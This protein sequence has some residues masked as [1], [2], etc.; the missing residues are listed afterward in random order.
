MTNY[1]Y[2]KFTRDYTDKLQAELD[3][4]CER[5]KYDVEL[6]PINVDV[7][8]RKKDI[9]AV[10]YSDALSAPLLYLNEKYSMF[11]DA[12]E[13]TNNINH[14]MEIL[15]NHTIRQLAIIKVD[16]PLDEP[17]TMQSVNR[18]VY[19]SAMNFDKNK[20]YLKDMPYEKVGDMALIAVYQI[21]DGN[22]FDIRYDFCQFMRMSPQEIFDIAH[23][24]VDR[25]KYKCEKVVDIVLGELQKGK[26]YKDYIDD[27]FLQNKDIPL[28]RLTNRYEYLGAPAI[29]SN[30]ALDVAFEKVKSDYPEMDSLYIMVSSRDELI[31]VPDKEIN[32]VEYLKKIHMDVQAE[33]GEGLSAHIYNYN[34]Y[35]KKLT[36]ADAPAKDK[37]ETKE[38]DLTKEHVKAR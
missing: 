1:N 17:F 34:G 10:K 21:D 38:F 18:K 19:L 35:T 33:F 32:D 29:M 5:E 25:D 12:F 4:Y 11:K 24:N 14:A 27:F 23:N 16:I 36:I 7:D 37:R 22:T 26:R 2:S 8:G 3:K 28:Y 31:V 9:L 20:E 6:I 15:I 30:N 13:M